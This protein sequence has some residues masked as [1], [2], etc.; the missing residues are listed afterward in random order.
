MSKQI[1]SNPSRISF[2]PGHVDIEELD[3]IADD[4]GVSRAELIREQ[5]ADLVERETDE[6]IEP[7]EL[8]KPDNEELRDAF[9]TLLRLSNNPLGPRPVS[10]DEAKSELYSQS[11][12]KETVKN[13]LLKPLA[14]LG[15]ITPRNGKVHIHRRTRE[16]VEAAEQR[17][18][19]ELE[20]LEAADRPEK[21]TLREGRE[22]MHQELLKY[23]RAGLN[24]PFQCL[25]WIATETLWNDD[26]GVSA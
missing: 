9:E 11:C 24:P 20:A 18:D 5:L 25:A 16:Q 15:F 6:E 4:R 8:H 7:E 22:P 2:D 3:E 1:E 12:K 17:A 23:Q 19:K 13:R 21:T 26:G 14:E 10:V